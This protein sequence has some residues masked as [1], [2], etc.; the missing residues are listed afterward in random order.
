MNRREWLT[1]TAAALGTAALPARGQ[2]ATRRLGIGHTGITWGYAPQNAEQAIADVARLGYHGFES[3]GSV[4]EYW[5]SRGGIGELLTA[6]GLP[7]VG[8]YCPMVLTDASLRAEETQKLVRWGRLIRRYGG[9]VAVI[10]PDNVDRARFDFAASRAAIV[11]ALDDF[12]MALADLG[13]V[14][15]L[16]Q[17]TGSCVTT[18]DETDAVMNA[19]DTSIVRLCPDTGELLNAGIDPVGFLRDYL[20]IV[21]HV[22]IKDFD[23]GELHDGYCP[24]GTGRVDVAGVIEVLE[25]S[26]ADC[27][28]MAELNPDAT[29]RS[30][31][32]GELARISKSTL[33]ALGYTF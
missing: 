19:V 14:A 26:D 28:I 22:H 33:Q 27:M 29:G 23:A 6:A 11:A 30:A 1:G 20:P 12:G 3:F 21:A 2:P 32:P 25:A 31:A 9:S 4:I 18:R 8:A 5:E 10:G 7:L 13:L 15:A 24:I 16:H 17:H